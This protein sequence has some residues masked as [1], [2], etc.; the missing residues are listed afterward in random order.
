M[1]WNPIDW[2]KALFGGAAG[3]VSGL[4]GGGSEEEARR[5]ALLEAQAGAAG[6][7][8]GRGELGYG[9][10]GKEADLARQNLADQASGKLSF[11]REALRQGLQQNIAAQ[12]ANAL[13]ASPQNAP[14]AARTAAMQAGRLGAG[15]S[16][17]QAMAGIAEQQAA[18]KALQ[19]AILA[20]RQQDMQVALGSRQN[21]IT[22]FGGGVPTTPEKSWMEKYGPTIATV[23]G[24]VASDRRLKTDV[25]GA[26]DD[27]RRMADGLKSYM[28]RYKS[29]E[30]GAGKHLGVMAQD[31]ERAGSKSVLDTPGGKMVHGARLATELAAVIGAQEKR[32]AKLEKKER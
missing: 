29:D 27:A 16:G 30:H 20:Q 22:G 5:K 17:Q 25:R 8:A 12:R 23:G 9:A 1:S 15:L 4:A 24:L 28:Y 2:G 13:S 31:L 6:R 26:D 10:L 3:A 11:S 21:A 7:F 19:D 14:M 32:L 18:A